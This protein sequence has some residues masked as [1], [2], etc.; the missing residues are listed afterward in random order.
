MRRRPI[1]AIAILTTMVFFVAGFVGM[2]FVNE[3]RGHE[4]AESWTGGN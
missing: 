2:F 1:C 3:K 4:A